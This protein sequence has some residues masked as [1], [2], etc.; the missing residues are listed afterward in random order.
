MKGIRTLL[1]P[2][3]V[4]WLVAGLWWVSRQNACG[5]IPTLGSPNGTAQASIIHLG[6]STPAV[7]EPSITKTE[8][9]PVTT[10]AEAPATAE[11]ATL[12]PLLTIPFVKNEQGLELTSE[13]QRWCDA[14]R[15]HLLSHPEA[16]ITVTGHADADGDADLNRRLSLRR[17]EMVRTELISMGI[18]AE[19][20]DATG[21]GADEPISDN[22]TSK[23]KAMNRRAE[24]HVVER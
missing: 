4:A 13:A 1:V 22:R 21:M 10:P 19:R 8:P 20:I 6:P 16:S 9:V 18:P 7:A 15:A 23:G 5:C 12:V 2:I 11:E 17:A 14:T 24:I 3:T